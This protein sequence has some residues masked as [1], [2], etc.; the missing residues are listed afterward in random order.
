MSINQELSNNCENTNCTNI[1]TRIIKHLNNYKW[2]CGD[3]YKEFK[4]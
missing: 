1:A 2:L 3:C 4:V